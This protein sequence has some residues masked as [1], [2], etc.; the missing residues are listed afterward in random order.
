MPEDLLKYF[1]FSDLPASADE[2]VVLLDANVTKP[3]HNRPG[4]DYWY[5]AIKTRSLARI[6][7]FGTRT[8]AF[9]EAN[10]R[11]RGA[12]VMN[13]EL[14]EAC[15]TALKEMEWIG[16]KFGAAQ[17][18]NAISGKK[19]T[20][21]R[22]VACVL[23]FNQLVVDDIRR[24]ERRE[25]EVVAELETL[26]E[27][28]DTRERRDALS[29]ELKQIDNRKTTLRNLLM[30]KH[31]ITICCFYFYETWPFV[32]IA[33]G[34]AGKSD[35]DGLVAYLSEETGQ[36]AVTI[37]GL[38]GEQPKSE[39]QSQRDRAT[40]RCASYPTMRAIFKALMKI[41]ACSA[42]AD[43]S[44][45][46]NYIQRLHVGI[47]NKTVYNEEVISVPQKITRPPYDWG[48]PEEGQEPYPA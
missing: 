46:S 9:F 14:L 5:D 25:T 3:E 28:D 20:F 32:E 48:P 34:P 1:I 8:A 43:H 30:P 31:C 15:Q 12:G 17:L 42:I 37:R 6:S 7:D 38:I 40:Q 24:A 2:A 29:D 36:T 22:A 21:E 47:G 11:G 26:A 4:A 33:I 44:A 19:L 35:M 27:G 10:H 23:G 16:E 41:E 18:K 13:A 45:R 39:E